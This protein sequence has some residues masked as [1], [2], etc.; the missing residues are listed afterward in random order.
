M[1]LKAKRSPEGSSTSGGKLRLTVLLAAVAAFLLV[2]VAS[3]FAAEKAVVKITGSGSGKV[4][5]GFHEKTT[6]ENEAGTPQIVCSYNGSTTSGVCENVP[7][8]PEGEGSALWLEAHPASGS[9][10]GGRTIDKGPASGD[11]PGK[12]FGPSD[13]R[14]VRA[15][16]SKNSKNSK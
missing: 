3:A 13:V 7:E 5:S 4:T 16:N 12:S 11:C 1:R 6:P 15:A 9:E 2:S 14:R 10:L 8:E